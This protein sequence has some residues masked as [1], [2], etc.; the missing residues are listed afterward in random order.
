MQWWHRWEHL[1]GITEQPGLE[2]KSFGQA[3]A[4]VYEKH[5][6]MKWQIQRW[7]ECQYVERVQHILDNE[8]KA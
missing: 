4:E 2:G 8:E 5:E 6:E 1:G 3:E 7:K